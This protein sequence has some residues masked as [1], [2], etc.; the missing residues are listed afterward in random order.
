MRTP[1][2]SQ[3]A[4]ALYLAHH[5]TT[6]NFLIGKIGFWIGDK[7]IDCVDKIVGLEIVHIYAPLHFIV[8][9]NNELR[10]IVQPLLRRTQD[11]KSP[12]AVAITR[13]GG[14]NRHVNQVWRDVDVGFKIQ[15][16]LQNL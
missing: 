9:W 12:L 2:I 10:I 15:S 14:Y 1:F 7:F 11:R 6:S 16:H 5:S 3:V 4:I 8:A 13:I